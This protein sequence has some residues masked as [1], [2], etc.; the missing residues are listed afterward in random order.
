MIVPG[1][2]VSSVNGSTNFVDGKYYHFYDFGLTNN[3]PKLYG[4]L[5]AGAK[6]SIRIWD[7]HY[8]NV[9]SDLFTSI[10]HDGICIEILTICQNGEDKNEMNDFANKVLEAIDDADV[11]EC[12]LWVYALMPK[13]YRKGIWNEWHDRF[14]IIDD[15]DVFLV[16]ASLDA[17]MRTR[18]SYGIY[19]LTETDDKNLVIDT[20][21]VYRDSIRDTSGGAE[22]NGHKC[23]VHRP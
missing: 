9:D 10:H 23:Y 15:T 21:K 5:L 8:L 17:H 2:D 12:K 7:P 16:G 13:L 4:D 1:R 22:G 18:K 11:Q 20:Y 3:P 6:S 19:Q 14:L